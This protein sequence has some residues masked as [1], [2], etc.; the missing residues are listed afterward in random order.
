A[1]PIPRLS[2]DPQSS[3]F[4]HLALHP[5]SGSDRKNWPE[6]KW[7]DLLE[8]LIQATNYQLLLIGGEAEG[9]RLHRL[10]QRVGVLPTRV[11]FAQSRALGELAKLRE[12]SAMFIGHDSG[13]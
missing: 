3:P 10:S 4:H 9:E 5:G 2:L 12:Q 13:I 7:A 1:D 11:R 8:H 6:D